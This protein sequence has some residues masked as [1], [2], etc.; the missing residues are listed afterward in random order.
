[1]ETLPFGFIAWYLTAGSTYHGTADT[2]GTT[3]IHGTS[4]STN[5]MDSTSNDLFFTGI[6]VEAT[7]D[8]IATDF[9]HRTFN[10][11]LL[12]C[13]RY[14]IQDF[15]SNIG[16]MYEAHTGANGRFANFYGIGQQLYRIIPRIFLSCKT[17]LPFINTHSWGLPDGVNNDSCLSLPPYVNSFKF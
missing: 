3:K 11:E 7:T 14:F 13:Q 1:M 15:A 5:Y 8:G 6:Q 9:E 2:W 12:L 17:K 10:Q 4:N 16:T